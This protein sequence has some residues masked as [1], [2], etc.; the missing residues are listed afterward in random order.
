[1]FDFEEYE[2]GYEEFIKELT[3]YYSNPRRF[4]YS[5]MI[6]CRGVRP[7]NLNTASL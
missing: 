1:M 6:C 3:E 2:G 5:P 7:F 4:Y